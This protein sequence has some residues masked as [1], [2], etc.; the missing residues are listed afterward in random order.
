MTFFPILIDGS[1][2][3]TWILKGL[4]ISAKVPKLNPLFYVERS[5]FS[6]IP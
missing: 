6:N 3:E 2:E 4:T 5:S 1:Q